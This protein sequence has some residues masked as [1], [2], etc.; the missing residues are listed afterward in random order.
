MDPGSKVSNI[1]GCWPFIGIS[2]FNTDKQLL[3]PASNQNQNQMSGFDRQGSLPSTPDSDCEEIDIYTSSKAAL[4]M[5]TREIIDSFLKQF[6]GLSHSRC[7]KKQVLSTMKRVVDILV[8]KHEKAY[9]GNLIICARAFSTNG[10]KWRISWVLCR[11][12]WEHLNKNKSAVYFSLSL[13]AHLVGCATVCHVMPH[14]WL[15]CAHL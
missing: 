9:N 7:A 11:N 6:S 14:V 3:I 10:I 2:G 5:N 4:D 15:K 13:Q 8:V 12:Q 1:G